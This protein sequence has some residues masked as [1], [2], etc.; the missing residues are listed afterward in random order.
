M[1]RP[2]RGA[3]LK[4]ITVNA[5]RSG[6]GVDTMWKMTERF[7]NSLQHAKLNS[8]GMDAGVSGIVC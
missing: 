2:R 1:M 4:L 7:I 8:L 3:V 5:N 6:N